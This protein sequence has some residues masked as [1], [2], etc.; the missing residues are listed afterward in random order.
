MDIS[1]TI[2]LR[3]STSTKETAFLSFITKVS[4]IG[5]SLGVMA[6]VIVVSV[7]NGFDSQLKHRILGAVPHMV[8]A[9]ELPERV[10]NSTLVVASGEFQQREGILIQGGINRMVAI[11]GIDIA[12][13]ARLSVVP[14]HMKEGSIADLTENRI[15]LGAS[16]ARQMGI[17][18]G[19]SLTVLIPEVSQTGNAVS[20][21]IARVELAG[22]FELNSE[23]DYSLAL[24]NL[25]YL[26]KIT[27]DSSHH[28][29][30]KLNNVFD[31][32][33]VR[34]LIDPSVVVTDWTEEYGD[35]FET[36]KMEKQM[37]FVLLTLIVM[38]A[39]FNTISGL[40]MMVKD[41][42]S[43]IAVL[44]TLGLSRV[45]V[46]RIFIVQGSLIGLIGT[47]IGIAVGLPLAYYVSD[48]VGF[49]ENLA[50]NRMLA[51]TYFDRVPSD[52]RLLD[53]I[54]IIGLSLFISIVTTIFPAYRA[55]QVEPARVLR[56][57]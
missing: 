57:E 39:A 23:L 43:E 22:T 15:I 20:P 3:F 54:V 6:L 21:K 28:Y 11:Y 51:G 19:D 49:F 26:K 46:M 56:G 7:M 27:G 48:I 34:N 40:S 2:G 12:H 1:D 38:I 47:F 30:L 35:F 32:T 8:I 36:V 10:E 52:I 45:G 37:M 31:V 24:M 13:E 5:L 16:I 41:K 17:W 50:G 53:I 9:G 4:M 14:E 29:R 18:I 44:R 42:Q 25:N 55:S 33:E